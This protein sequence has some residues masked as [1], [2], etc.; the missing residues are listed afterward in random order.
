MI[1]AL[2]VVFLIA[3]SL[4]FIEERL[5]VT[6]KLIAYLLMGIALIFIAGTRGIYD[7]PDSWEYED[8]Y[9][10]AGSG[11]ILELANEPTFRYISITLRGMGF[12][13]NALFFVYASISVPLHLAS[14]WKLSRLPILTMV[15]Y[16]SYYYQ[17]HDLVQI[18]SSIASS[19]FLFAFYFYANKRKLYALLFILAGTLFHYSAAAGLL[20]FLFN[21]K[22]WNAWQ[23]WAAYLMVPIG[24]VFYY[25]SIDISYLVPE[26]LGGDKLEAYRKLR[27]MGLE[28]E[29]A[30]WALKGNLVIWMNVCLFY[31]AII[32]RNTL[33]TACKYS[34]LAI[35]VLGLAFVCLFFLHNVSAVLA[36]RLCDYFEV[37]SIILWTAAV[38]AFY[39]VIAGKV[40]INTVS[41][42]R[43]VLSML[44]YAMAQL[45]MK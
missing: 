16:L 15:V 17:M 32:F 7:T 33:Q 34:F 9:Y 18:R 39:P 3:L 2:V 5:S 27:D 35:K 41:S 44:F 10:A 21:D 4:S 38:Y 45:T 26:G 19:L 30:G 14:F 40:I 31:C 29:Q 23:R 6:D 11:S 22:E 28:D 42:I 43:F 1:L 12:G 25:S 36:S 37:T 13:I 8:M 24:I 20:L